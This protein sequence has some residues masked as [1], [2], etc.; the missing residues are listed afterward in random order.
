MLSAYKGR[1]ENG[2]FILPEFDKASIPNNTNI[3][4]TVLEDTALKTEL[5]HK[6]SENLAAR[7]FYTA[8]LNLRKDGFSM[9]DEAA[10]DELQNGKYKLSFEDRL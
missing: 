8:M 6:T 2:N 3:I 1:Y 10:I 9:E 5:M 7:N 4:I